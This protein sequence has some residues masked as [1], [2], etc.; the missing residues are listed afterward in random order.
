MFRIDSVS[1]KVIYDIQN[2]NILHDMNQIK[3]LFISL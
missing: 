1:L 3:L 2:I